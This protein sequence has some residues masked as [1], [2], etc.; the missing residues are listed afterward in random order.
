MH[1][2]IREGSQSRTWQRSLVDRHWPWCMLVMMT[3]TRMTCLEGHMNAIV[4]QAMTGG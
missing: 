1:I 3:V 4:N 2:M